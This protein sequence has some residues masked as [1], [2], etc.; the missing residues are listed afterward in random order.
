MNASPRRPGFAYLLLVAG[1]WLGAHRFYLGSHAG[2]AAQLA[3]LLFGL[4]GYPGARL[5]LAVLLAWLL[6]DIYW[7]HRRTRRV[8]PP[9]APRAG[10]ADA[11]KYDPAGLAEANRLQAQF[12]AAAEAHDWAAAVSIGEQI[13]AT[14]RRVFKG[15]HPNLAMSLCMLGQACY[16]LKALDKARPALE[17]SLAIGL[18]I[19]MPAEDMDITRKALSLTLSGISERNARG[20][21]SD[22]DAAL[23]N[24]L[25][26]REMRCHAALAQGDL[27]RAERFGA[28]AVAAARD[29][30]GGPGKAVVRQL[31]GYAEVCRRLQWNDKA[32]ASAHEALAMAGQLGLDDGWQRGPTNTLALLHAAAGRADEAEALYK[33]TIAMAVAEARGGSS[34]SVLRAFNNLAFLY[35]ESGQNEKAELCY[36][37]ALVHLDK[38]DQGEGGAGSEGDAELHSHMLNNF[39]G[40]L[41]ARR[42]FDRARSLYERSLAIQ[43]RSCRGISTAAANAHNDL[44]LIAQDEG[45]LRQAL[46]HFKRTLLLNQICT[47]DHFKNIDS[48]QRSIDSVS[49]VLATVARAARMEPST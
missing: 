23:L 8:R 3:L 18:K 5:A 4:S 26:D 7:V 15:P 35:A 42:D 24:L 11:P 38:L 12:F 36:G 39:G 33:K 44:G 25:E 29:L 9:S 13:V 20:A 1:G 27:P 43:Q 45:D 47:P 22:R 30:C 2:G 16:Q 31:A 6:F 14:A 21:A 46:A 34:D 32:E 17:E 37:R 28:E 49:M 19:G 41:M 10:G 48:A 40:L